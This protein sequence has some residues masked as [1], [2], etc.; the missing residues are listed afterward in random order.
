VYDHP[1][2]LG[3]IGSTG[4]TA[5][6]AIAREADVVIG[7]GT[8]YSDFTTASRTVFQNLDVR[9]VNV[10]VAGL[11]AIKQAGLAVQAD[12]RETLDALLPL[13]EG[14]RVGEGYVAKYTELNAAWEETVEKVYLPATPNAGADGLLTQNEVIG[15]VNELS[16]PRDVVAW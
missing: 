1:Q 2:C 7:I 12:A 8:R 6:N 14:Y 10:N 11:D 16:D 4:T 5:A 13:L 15:M 9:F 3:A